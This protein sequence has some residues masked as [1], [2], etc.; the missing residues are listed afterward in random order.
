MKG[1]LKKVIKALFPLIPF[2]SLRIFALKICGYSIGR[3]VYLPS[4]LVISDLKTRTK[5][6]IIKDRVSIGP[7]VLIITDSSPNN[8]RLKKIFPL[9]SKTVIIEEDVWIGANVTILPGVIIEKCSVIGAG[10]IV[11]KD[12]PPFSVV[13]GNPARIIRTIDENEI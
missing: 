9:L 8:S 10:S 3:N 1:L 12:V 4:S 2:L 13:I 7:N 5:N 6:L 11:T